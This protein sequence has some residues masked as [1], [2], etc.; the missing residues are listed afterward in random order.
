MVKST[1]RWLSGLHASGKYPH[2]G[3][4]GLSFAEWDATLLANFE[5]HFW[6]PETEAEDKRFHVDPSVIHRRGIYKVRARSPCFVMSS[7]SEWRGK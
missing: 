6:V 1:V 2:S 3:V 4:E 5:R 7:H